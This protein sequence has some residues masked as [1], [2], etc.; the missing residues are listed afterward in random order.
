[1]AGAWGTTQ[2]HTVTD[3]VVYS[4]SYPQRTALRDAVS[5]NKREAEAAVGG[6]LDFL[7]AT[8]AQRDINVADQ[9]LGSDPVHA[10]YKP[11]EPV[12]YHDRL[13]D[14]ERY[15]NRQRGKE[16]TMVATEVLH[17][18]S[19]SQPQPDAGEAVKFSNMAQRGDP[20]LRN[21]LQQAGMPGTAGSQGSSNSSM[22]VLGSSLDSVITD[23][24]Q[25]CH[26]ANRAAL[27]HAVEDV[28][29]ECLTPAVRQVKPVESWVL[30]NYTIIKQVFGF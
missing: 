22:L 29:Q 7:R 24:N 23:Q 13:A 4:Q 6:P 5:H 3:A 1:M 14:V 27:D 8:Q 12:N 11:Q 15:V 9:Q 30:D 18:A 2:V 17:F 19:G 28:L 20:R 10:F 21:L 26:Y 16:V 25:R